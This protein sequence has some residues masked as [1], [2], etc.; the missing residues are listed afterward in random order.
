VNDA[1][2]SPEKPEHYHVVSVGGVPVEPEPLETDVTSDTVTVRRAPRYGTFIA[3]G[4]V[5]GAVVALI[6]TFAFSGQPA[7]EGELIEFDKGQVFGFLLLVCGTV[8]AALGAVV[9][10]VIDRTTAR[11][12]RSVSVEHESTHHPEE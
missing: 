10:L 4:A 3:L 6:L 11:R 7:I 12:A 9:A 2:N 8:G 1:Q 5:L